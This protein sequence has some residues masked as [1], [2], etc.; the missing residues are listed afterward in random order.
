MTPKRKP[1]SK[2]GRLL[3]VVR[4]LLRDKI[5]QEVI[6]AGRSVSV[7]DLFNH[8]ETKKI[9]SLSR[10]IARRLEREDRKRIQQTLMFGEFQVTFIKPKRKRPQT[11]IVSATTK[12]RANALIKKRY[13][14]QTK[15]I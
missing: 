3:C 9:E 11:E 15:I 6:A 7:N 13:G 4:E 1:K 2:S 12:R 10:R 8:P 5:K 14:K